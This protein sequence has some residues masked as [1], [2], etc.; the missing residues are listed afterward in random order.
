M[1]RLYE[2][3][4]EKK[5]KY[6]SDIKSDLRVLLSLS[7]KHIANIDEELITKGF[8]F[9]VDEFKD[10]YRISGDPYYTHPLKVA[11]IIMNEMNY[12][13]N[14]TIV[15]ALLHDIIEDKKNISYTDINNVFGTKIADIVEGVTKIKGE[16]TQSLDKAATYSKLFEALVKDIRVIL[17]KLADRLDNLRT[18]NYMRPDKQRVIAKETLNFYTPFAQRLGLI[19]IKR[20]LEDLSLYFADREKYEFIKKA[21]DEKQHEFISIIEQLESQISN[22]LNDKNVVH[23]LAL[24]HKHIYEIY[25]MIEQGRDISDIDNFFSVVIKLMTND[26]SE[27]YRA[28][29]IIANLLGPVRSFDD[30]F[31]KPKINFYKALHSTHFTLNQ[32]LVEV[33]I[34]TEEMDNLIEKGMI[35]LLSIQ[36]ATKNLDLNE[37]DL[38]EWTTWMQ[39]LVNEGEDDAV[40]KIWGTIQMNLD[41][42]YVTVFTPEKKD[43]L[44]PSK[45]ST[46]DLAFLIS[47]DVGLHYVSAKVNGELKNP[48]YELKNND[49]VEIITSPNSKPDISWNNYVITFK[50]VVKLSKYFMEIKQKSN[51]DL[52]VAQLREVK[53]RITG[54]DRLGMLGDITNSIGQI[55][56]LRVN[57]YKTNDS[58]FEGIFTLNLPNDE[59][60]NELFIRLFSV[61]GLTSVDMID[62]ESEFNNK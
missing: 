3:E 42:E 22:S 46:L 48:K 41:R 40:Q 26:Y 18:L 21:L 58:K 43:Y 52:P 19:K 34:R 5:C 23:A 60:L 30:Y 7:R 39:K 54:D 6:G 38:T 8:Y 55:N 35:G 47:E 15:A 62:T 51:D 4:I 11:L 29:G 10:M 25:K 36:S 17:I 53:F 59:M 14:E 20:K 32:K 2:L 45:A 1:I 57:L 50:A 9:C 44:L 61:K 28:Y 31:A 24:E 33:I 56:I 27:C 37:E 12:A 16:Y 49:T 13:D